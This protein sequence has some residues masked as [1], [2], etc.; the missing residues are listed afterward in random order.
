[1]GQRKVRLKQSRD[2]KGAHLMPLPP[3]RSLT[4]AALFAPTI[5]FLFTNY[6]FR[7]SSQPLRYTGR[8]MNGADSGALD[9]R[10]VW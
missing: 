1:M 6:P 10:S 2:R 4:V 3:K 8:L 9:A 7:I 5:P